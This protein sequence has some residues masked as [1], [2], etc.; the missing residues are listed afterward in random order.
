MPRGGHSLIEPAAAGRPVLFGPH[1]EN[2]LDAREALI[3]S[4]GGQTVTMATFEETCAALLAD[5]PRRDAMGSRA[6]A[7]I[8]SSEG[9]TARS[10]E[11]LLPLLRTGDSR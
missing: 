8:R 3:P 6:L 10:V 11:L 2:F 7:A 5:A 9:A 1:V 4:G